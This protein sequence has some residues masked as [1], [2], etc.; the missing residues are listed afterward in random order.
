[1]PVSAYLLYVPNPL[2]SNTSV[3]LP[4]PLR[5]RV[6]LAMRAEG[7]D[8]YADFARSALI[9]KCRVIEEQLR[10][11]NPT[12]YKDLYGGQS[13]YHPIPDPRKD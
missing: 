2:K 3:K 5:N 1:M 9:D 8:N 12:E 4:E 6:A 13:Y 10:T 7:I 11:R